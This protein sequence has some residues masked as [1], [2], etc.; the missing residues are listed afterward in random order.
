MY[1]NS[2][3]VY[4]VNYYLQL[5]GLETEIEKSYSQDPIA[6]QLSNI[7]DLSLKN[8]GKVECCPV[9]PDENK[10]NI[11]ADV[12]ENRLAYIAVQFTESLKQ[13]TILGY[14]EN[15]LATV[16][17][18]QLQTLEDLLLYLSTL[19]I[20]AKSES[21]LGKW[22]EGIVEEGWQR[23]EELFT[24]QQLGLAFMNEVSV[25]RGQE[26]DL[27]IQLN[28]VSVALVTKVTQLTNTEEKEMSEADILMQV[29]PISVLNL[30]SELM[31]QIKDSSGEIVLETSS[32]EGDNWIQLAFSAEY[33]ESFQVLVSYE[34]AVITKNFVI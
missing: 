20:E 24:P 10:F 21:K 4:S 33:G 8:I 1:L 15:P 17:I 11:T 22:L 28:Q 12:S 34:D 14:V 13:G 31:L 30:P 6:V 29:R 16:E 32:R 3:A 26:L 25:I 23:V 2:L 7:A 27:G 9:L 19:E 18:N 5:M